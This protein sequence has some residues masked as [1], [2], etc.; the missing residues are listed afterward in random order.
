MTCIPG[1]KRIIS[2]WCMIVLAVCQVHAQDDCE[3]IAEKAKKLYEKGLFSESLQML[4]RCNVN[5]VSADERFEIYRQH[6]RN[7]MELGETDSAEYYAQMMLETKPVYLRYPDYETYAFMRMLN[8][9]SITAKWELGIMLGPLWSSPVVATS[10]NITQSAV[11]YFTTVQPIYGG[12]V[13]Y[14]FNNKWVAESGLRIQQ[15][16]IESTTPDVSGW[17]FSY[18]ES[19][20]YITIPMMI[21]R[22]WPLKKLDFTLG[23]GPEFGILSSSEAFLQQQTI[24]GEAEYETY[25]NTEDNRNK[26]LYTA[27][28]R[29]GFRKSGGVM[30]FGLHYNL[31]FTLNPAIPGDYNIGQLGNYHF[32]DKLYLF[33]HQVQVSIYIPNRYRISKR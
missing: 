31:G 33:L 24:G 11:T 2:V 10:N 17:N 12:S 4:K 14:S 20:N 29:A 16:S 30:N 22:V 25:I 15:I 32:D 7:F 26:L 21:E 6:A 23:A 28:I 3:I 9:F 5:Y 8:K 13:R 27:N 19:Q 1:V 18:I